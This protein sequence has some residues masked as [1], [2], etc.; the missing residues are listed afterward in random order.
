[1]SQRRVGRACDQCNFSRTRCDGD[2]PCIG[3]RSRS[4]SGFQ[5]SASPVE[6][7]VSPE[8]STGD[9]DDMLA[10]LRLAPLHGLDGMSG[11]SNHVDID[12]GQFQIQS[13]Q[14]GLDQKS[15]RPDSA[16]RYPCLK[17]LLPA[18]K[19][20]FPP[21]TACDLL[22]IFFAE[23]G[24]SLCFTH[25]PY[26]L[27]PVLRKKWFLHPSRPR[28]TSPALLATM[29]WCVAHTAN[30]PIFH[31]PGSRQRII[32]ELYGVAISLLQRRDMDNWRR[33][34]GGWQLEE[35][36]TTSLDPDRLDTSRRTFST[37][38]TPCADDVLT[39]LLL[40]IVISGGEYKSDCIKWWNKTV[41]LIK[42][43][44]LHKEPS[45]SRE[46]QGSAEEHEERR[47]VFWLAYTVDRHLA[48]SHNR[49][50]DILDAECEVFNPLPEHLWQTFDTL[51]MEAL[52]LRTYGP[53]MTISGT[54]FFEYFL[55]MMAIL[56]DIIDFRLRRYH[57]RLVSNDDASLEVIMANLTRCERSICELSDTQSLSH[58]PLGTSLQRSTA[59]MVVAYAVYIIK[60][61]YVLV[62]GKWDAITMLEDD[63]DW[64]TSSRFAKCSASSIAAA[65]AISDILRVDP[66]LSF[67]PYL[68]GIYLFH[69][70]FVLLLFAER[71]SRIGPNPSVEEACEVIIR[72]HEVAIVT[73]STEFQ[74]VL[75]KA[76]RSLLYNAR[77]SELS[78]A[79]LQTLRK[80][81][82]STYRWTM[83]HRGL[84]L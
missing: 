27:S 66:E 51:N 73:L 6:L 56:G 25:S 48:L 7:G 40:T 8:T 14:L 34:P 32:N 71:M 63:G 38:P 26:V 39:F 22:D 30:S 60:V 75:R 57:P 3:A 69:G 77:R 64:I 2:L 65:Q 62:Y 82:L 17:P 58:S 80:E 45:L 53:P 13:P 70:S 18:L 83:G 23:P 31:P 46:W 47:R 43:L 41:A 33:V 35:D 78:E 54:G 55:P 37:G 9:Q 59:K 24:D 67:M 16:C 11:Q 36:F 74:K 1:M 15:H 52:E 61:L 81:V 49:P 19:D 29:L 44:G 4:D 5:T 72:A 84:C 12:S 68:F 50:L 28:P 21:A 42:H 20:I 10:S 76:F 79:E